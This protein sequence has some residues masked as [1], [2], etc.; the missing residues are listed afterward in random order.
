MNYEELSTDAL[1]DLH[2]S[3]AE[4]YR[5][6]RCLADREKRL[7]QLFGK[8]FGVDEYPD[9]AAHVKELERQLKYRGEQFDS[10]EL[11]SPEQ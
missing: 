6:D 8:Y 4:A 11:N 3:C 9:W 2:T 7:G 10:I 1:K 5:S